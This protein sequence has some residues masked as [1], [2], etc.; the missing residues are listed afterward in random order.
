MGLLTDP[1]AG[2]GR[3][4]QLLVTYHNKLI[5][6]LY[7]GGVLWFMILAHKHFNAGTYFSENALLPGLVKGEFDEDAI[8]KVY[9]SELLDEAAKYPNGVPYSWLIAKFRQ[10]NL[11]TYTHN[12]TLT[13]PLGL[14][15]KFTGKNVYAILRAPRSSSTEALVLSVPYRPPS[16][17]NPGT[18]PSIA[19]MLAV[20]K[21]FRRQ[22]YWAKDVI[23]LVTEHEQLGVQA[24]LEAYHKVTCGR[25][26]VLD[27]GDMMGRGGAIQAAINLELHAEKIGHIDVKIEGLNGQLPNLDLVNLVHRMCSKEGVK[28]TFKNRESGNYR[29]WYREWLHSF[30]TLMAM[31]AT[32][33]SGVPNGNHGLFHRFGIEAVTLEGF[34]KK[35]KGSPALYFQVG[36]VL[37]G[38]FRSLNNLLERFHQSYFF[39]LLPAADRFISIGMYMPPLGLICAG[40]VIKAFAL[41]LKMQ[42]DSTKKQPAENEDTEE[43]KSKL[44]NQDSTNNFSLVPVGVTVLAAHS[45][46]IVML[47]SPQKLNALG[48]KFGLSTPLALYA[49][50]FIMTLLMSILPL[51]ACRHIGR[52]VESRSIFN[53][54][55]LLELATILLCTSMQNFSLALLSAVVYVPSG[56]LMVPT[57]NRILTILQKIL[58]VFLHPLW[59]LIIVVLFHTTLTFPDE[60]VLVLSEMGMRAVL[61]ALVFAVVD[62]YIYAN[63][64]F[65]VATA[66]LLPNW[67]LFWIVLHNSPYQEK[68]EE[69]NED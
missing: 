26:G 17:V 30:K 67:I 31:V 20:A 42:E 23:F 33:A 40:L 36:R 8:A 10:L 3:L 21:F 1:G 35:G 6:L 25:S 39:Y 18:A 68:K 4:T 9:Q 15:N 12:F 34:E 41:W 56:L 52:T 43:D 29:D 37:E 11:D 63:W 47:S 55:A 13:Y 7:I 53:I 61:K 32:Q 38:L 44:S 51:F 50:Y 49:G 14:G 16:S 2:H 45:V 60:S 59:L 5:I 46:S 19:I 57:Q 69:K 65:P 48:L 22:K 24:W 64:L 62:S 58:W 54:V 66:I 28:H 27:H